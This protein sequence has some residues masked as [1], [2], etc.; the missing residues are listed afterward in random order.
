MSEKYDVNTKLV[1]EAKSILH[2]LKAHQKSAEDKF[3]NLDKQIEDVKKSQRLLTEAY[4]KAAPE[5]S[6]KDSMLSKYIRKDGT[7]RKRTE[8]DNIRIHGQGTITAERKGLLDDTPV[9][10]WQG[11][12]QKIVRKRNFARMLMANPH[13]PKLDVELHKHLELTPKN[14][15]PMVQKF[16]AGQAGGGAEWTQAQF[17]DQL[18]SDY[19]TPRRLRSLLTEVAVDR[20][21]LIV[22]TLTK[23]GQPYVQ[24]SISDDDRTAAA[25]Q[26][27]ASTVTTAQS[28]ISMQG[29]T[30]RYLVDQA[31]LEDSAL[32]LAQI[33]S[34]DISDSLES[35]FE[36]AMLNG[37]TDGAYDDAFNS[38]SPRG[39][40]TAGSGTADHRRAFDGF[41]R[42]ANDKSNVY[43]PSDTAN[44]V[45]ADLVATLSKMGEYG[46]SDQNVI[47]ASPEAIVMHFLDLPELTTISN[48]SNP[49]SPIISGQLA[50]IMG[51]PLVA[52]R[53]M[54]ADLDAGNGKYTGSGT[55]TGFVIFNRLSYVQYVRRGLQV[56][57]QRDIS[58]GS[59][60]MVASLRAVMG[61]AD[62][63][64]ADNVSYCYGMDS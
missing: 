51:M 24:T 48:I 43:K 49:N 45:L 57:T 55:A 39:R 46:G 13:T 47:V 59:L 17:I 64:G 41:R 16:Y 60:T 35:G 20:G 52:S 53:Y 44:F 58:S 54:T 15:A 1:E 26:Y 27:K 40:W 14:I 29:L 11:Q 32:A 61:T 23:G 50:S 2:G 42:L 56:E 12:L 8:K 21:S 62:S 9:C 31:V 22:P 6:G 18:H 5:Y 33:L 10:E 38:W 28:T 4:T 25:N 19:S 63:T 3:S 34:R 37:Q 7:L 30:V 36:D